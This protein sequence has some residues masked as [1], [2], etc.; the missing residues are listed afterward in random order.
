MLT[1]RCVSLF[2]LALA[3]WAP[4]ISARQS[5]SPAILSDSKIR[6]DV[7]VTPKSGPPVSGL[8]LQD[9]TVLDNGIPQ[10]IDLKAVDGRQA[11]IEVI[12]VIDAVNM[13]FREVAV[14][15][16]EVDKFLKTDGG[17]L[18]HPTEVVILTDKG[19]Q[20]QGDFSQDGNA[21]STA[22]GHYT[23]PN[24][25][26]G[27]PDRFQISFQ[28]FAELVAQERERPGRKMIIWVSPGWP[29]L[30]DKVA[31]SMQEH[32]F[33]NGVELWKQLREGRITVYSVDPSAIVDLE[34]GLTAVGTSRL[35]PSDENSYAD[36]A[37]R[38]GEIHSI[39]LT[40]P[41]I[42]IQTGGLALYPGNDIASEL[43]RCMA[44]ADAYY[45]IS[46]E[47]AIADQPNEFHRLEIRIAKPGLIGRTRQGY[48]WQA[49]GAERLAAGS[50]RLRGGDDPDPIDTG[51]PSI[52]ANVHPYL[53]LPYSQLLDRI[54]ELKTLQPAPDQQRL[55]AILQK[56]GRG[57]DD[58]AR[59][60]GDLIAHESVLQ[61]KLDA[62]GKLKAKERFQDEYL[63]LHHGH[64]WGARA[65][66]RMDAK[67]NRLGPIGLE[68]GYAVTS[69]FALTCVSFST[70]A[71]AQSRF[72]YLGDQTIGSRGTYVL[73]FVQKPGEV[74]FGTTMKGTGGKNIDMLTQGILWID[75]NNFQIIRMRTDL[76]MPRQEIRLER[77]TTEVTLAEVRLP[78]LP[79]PLWLPDDVEVYL[80]IQAH[81]YRNVHHYTNY[82]RYR[83][84]VKI[85]APQ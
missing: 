17:R 28:G 50:L 76:L 30:R 27:A 29:P 60:I 41:V 33:G 48:Y 44:D 10:F 42:A 78:D 32:L 69:G 11:P 26:S 45:E 3:L 47:P 66:Y 38:P 57:V 58:F 9:F 80:D 62:R 75:Q 51:D 49:S 13:G 7:V 20:V 55:P 16:E 24:I 25:G 83:V 1:N 84:S 12:L 15:R 72:R 79:D 77:A 23:V 40:L 53:D 18:A 19:L 82:R 65:E 61:E 35:R 74:T 71:Q 31:D 67:G 43:Q 2:L 85:G 5:V 59:N 73:G 64:E 63:I 39:G 54:P 22:L 46:F 4:Q 52:Y 36:N 56:M 37:S 68:K 6:L 81:Q 8:E 14:T 34:P 70:V 21:I